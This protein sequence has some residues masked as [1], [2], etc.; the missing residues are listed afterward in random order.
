MYA[1]SLPYLYNYQEALQKATLEKK[2][3]MVLV[4]TTY[5]PWC[6]RFKKKTLMNKKIQKE[7]LKDYVVVMLNKETDEMPEDLKSRLVPTT[8]FLDNKGEEFYS[9]IGY[10]TVKQFK[11]DLTD[12]LDMRDMEDIDIDEE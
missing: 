3:V 1:N 6:K 11:I 4:V 7:I 9:A 10:R 5:C 12:S 8:F 2:S